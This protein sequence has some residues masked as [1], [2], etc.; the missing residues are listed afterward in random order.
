MRTSPP[1]HNFGAGALSR[2]RAGRGCEHL[3]KRQSVLPDGPRMVGV[4]LLAGVSVA[5]ASK[6]LNG[7]A[8]VH[9]DTR[10]RVIEASERISFTGRG[11]NIQKC[12]FRSQPILKPEVY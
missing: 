6:A 5:T 11:R 7:R 3:R 10:R 2:D 12:P 8:N 1:S 9:P 4:A